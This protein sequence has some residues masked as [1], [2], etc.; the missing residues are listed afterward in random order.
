MDP[1]QPPAPAPPPVNWQSPPEEAGPAP[2]VKFASHG[3]RLA[4]YIID[5]VILGI[6]II[7]A[8]VVFGIV[9]VGAVA[10]DSGGAAIGG[11]LLYVVLILLVSFAYFPYFWWKGGQTPGM[12]VFHLRVVRDAD[13]GP[14]SGMSAFLRLIG[15]W[16]NSVVFYIGYIWIFIDK[17]RRG[18]HDLIAGTVVI[19]QP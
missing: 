14:I 8:S 6:V 7:I 18:W 19:E 1:Q 5:A 4:A 16:V 10:T 12:K 17:R 3:A 2:G 15:F 11:T 13:G 9:F